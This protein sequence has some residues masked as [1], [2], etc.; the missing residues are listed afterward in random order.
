MGKKCIHPINT[1]T[2]KVR[3]KVYYYIFEP[4]QTASIYTTLYSGN[5]SVSLR[6]K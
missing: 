5:Y 1:C 2:R 3:R 4:I 6:E